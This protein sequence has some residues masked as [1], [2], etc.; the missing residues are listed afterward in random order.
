MTN[1]QAPMTNDQTNPKSEWPNDEFHSLV[2]WTFEIVTCLVIGAWSLVIQKIQICHFSFG[3]LKSRL[4][5]LAI[6]SDPM[7][8]I[9]PY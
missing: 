5:S 9:T 1:D 8:P 4:L 7:V 2:I 3:H 6:A